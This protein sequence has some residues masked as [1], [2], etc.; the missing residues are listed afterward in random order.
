MF[1]GFITMSEELEERLQWDNTRIHAVLQQMFPYTPD[2]QKR[3]LM[4]K[5]YHNYKK[6]YVKQLS[7]DPEKNNLSEYTF[8]RVVIQF[9]SCHAGPCATR[10]SAHLS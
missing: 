1:Q 4:T 9:F 8:N 5:A 7:F 3:D 10:G 2:D 6:Q